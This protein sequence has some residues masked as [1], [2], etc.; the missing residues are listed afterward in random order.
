MLQGDEEEHAVLLTNYFLGINKKAWLVLGVTSSCTVQCTHCIS[1]QL[2]RIL[3][4]KFAEDKVREW[5]HCLILLKITY[6]LS[7]NHQQLTE[8]LSQTRHRTG[9]WVCYENQDLIAV[10]LVYLWLQLA[11]MLGIYGIWLI[12]FKKFS[13][14]EKQ[15]QPLCMLS[16]CF[17]IIL[18]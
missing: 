9:R 12:V 13:E 14:D 17:I 3:V 5:Q 11:R 10:D 4:S 2:C 7:A 8:K 6:L 16:K 15:M 1:L 18:H